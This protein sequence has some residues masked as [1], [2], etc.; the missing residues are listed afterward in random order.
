MNKLVNFIKKPTMEKLETV[1][2]K[3]NKFKTKYIYSM[4]FKSMGR[5]TIIEKPLKLLNSNN[6]SIGSNV[7]IWKNAR[8]EAVK[9]YNQSAFNPVLIIEDGVTIQQ[10]LHLTCANKIIIKSEVAIA[11]NVTITD[12]NHEYKDIT[13]SI[14]KQDISTNAVII[15]NRCKLYNNSVILPGTNIGNHCVIGANSVVSGT[16]PDFSVVVGAPA[17]IVKRYNLNKKIWMATNP[18]GEFIEE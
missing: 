17:R 4:Y 10:N 8:I 13:M 12:I 14:E 7:L 3:L 5:D 9:R 11:S 18:S 2:V 1:R 15:G 6:I 16:I